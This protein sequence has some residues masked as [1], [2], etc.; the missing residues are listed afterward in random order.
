MNKINLLVGAYYCT[1][2]TCAQI[3]EIFKYIN[4]DGSIIQ[5]ELN[6][7]QIEYLKLEI[8]KYKHSFEELE[9][10]KKNQTKEEFY[11]IFDNMI[12][13]FYNEFNL[14]NC[15]KPNITIVEKFPHPF[16]DRNYKAMT[17]SELH[18]KQF[19]VPKGIYLLEKYTIHGISEIM[20]AHEIMH[21]VLNNL[22]KTDELLN[23]EPFLSEGIVDFTSQYLLLKYNIID[24]ICLKNW[25]EFGRANCTVDY[26]GNLYFREAKQILLIAKKC[27]MSEIKKLIKQG[28]RILSNMDMR[29]YC[30]KDNIVIE[31][32]V[33]NK[34]VSL[35]DIA[36]SEFVLSVDELCLF[37]HLLDQTDGVIMENIFLSS[38]EQEKIP[39][40]L[41]SLQKKG[42]L[43][44]LDNKVFNTNFKIFSTIKIR[45]V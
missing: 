41:N 3:D 15:E 5:D 31:D 17:F 4:E 39:L 14:S 38:I 13:C 19:N 1:N 29:D 21:Y 23:Q 25:I 18:E 28:M 12:E 20:I 11:K 8:D 7:L 32:K 27:G 6:E 33:L 36:L 43:Y 34:L 22:T 10:H 9:E 16:E 2:N 35:Y 42:L 44:I 40:I 37:K 26:I 30:F 24:E 45:L